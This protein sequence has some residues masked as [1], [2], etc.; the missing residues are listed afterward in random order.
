MN[1]REILETNHGNENDP[2]EFGDKSSKRM[3]M[4]MMHGN[5]GKSGKKH[6]WEELLEFGAGL[7]TFHRLSAF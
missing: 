6:P 5:C 3:E 2:P 1:S 7:G 4:R